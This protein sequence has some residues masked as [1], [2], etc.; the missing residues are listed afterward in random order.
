[1]KVYDGE[2]AFHGTKIR[3]KSVVSC[4]WPMTNENLVCKK[5]KL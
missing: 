2:E 4:Q 1:M 5:E 3:G